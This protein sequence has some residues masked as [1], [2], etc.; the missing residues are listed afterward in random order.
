VVVP[1]VAGS[2]SIGK[3]LT[4]TVGSFTL[5]F[6][7]RLDL[8]SLDE[9][10]YAIIAQMNLAQSDG[11][12]GTF[13]YSLGSGASC[14]FQVFVNGVQTF[15]ALPVPPLRQWFH[16]TMSYDSATGATATQSGV[17]VGGDAGAGIVVAPG[18]ATLIVG[19][20]YGTPPQSGALTY[21]MDDVVLQGTE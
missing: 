5:S 15:I 10:P 19:D 7:L 2:N 6:D 13:N 16:V 11:G 3:V 12:M 18:T 9:I 8:D 4:G 17:A 1:P 14:A 20:V 21:S